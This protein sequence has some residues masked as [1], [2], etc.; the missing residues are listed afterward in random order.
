VKF[1]NIRRDRRVALLMDDEYKYLLVEGT[2]RIAKER[3]PLKDIETLAIR[4]LGKEQGRKDFTAH[5]A[6]QRRVSIEISPE[7][8]IESL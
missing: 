1:R 4:Y 2:A 5:Y 3:D 8:V 6:K 7:K